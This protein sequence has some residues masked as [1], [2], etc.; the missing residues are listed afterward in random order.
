MDVY[1]HQSVIPETSGNQF[2]I[3]QTTGFPISLRRFGNDAAW[4]SVCPDHM[5][6][7][8]GPPS[9]MSVCPGHMDVK[10]GPPHG[11]RC[12]HHFVI[13]ETSGIQCNK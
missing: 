1:V 13:P 8:E 2:N 3:E 6:V 12:A 5:D 7:K 10:E 11:C 9:G 4:M